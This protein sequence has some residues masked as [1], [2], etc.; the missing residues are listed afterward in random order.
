MDN[1]HIDTKCVQAGYRPENG[2]PR[3]IPIIQSTTFKYD[4]SE[5]MG[6]LFDLEA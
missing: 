6:K 5:E 4:S 2:E 3:Q 1:Y